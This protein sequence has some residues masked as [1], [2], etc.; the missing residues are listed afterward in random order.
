MATSKELYAW[1]YTLKG[2][3]ASVEEASVRDDMLRLAAKLEH[4]A[5]CK[6]VSER[7]LV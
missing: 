4:L 6:A 1:V 5:E 7:Q 2:W 3:M